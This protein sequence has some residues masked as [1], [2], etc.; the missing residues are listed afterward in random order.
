MM[1]IFLLVQV[2]GQGPV[3]LPLLVEAIEHE[4]LEI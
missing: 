1:L 3:S 2:R 4:P